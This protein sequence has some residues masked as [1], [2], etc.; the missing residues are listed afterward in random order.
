M[1]REPEYFTHPMLKE[2]SLAYRSYQM[3][4][5]SRA[6]E[7][8]SLVVLPTG[9]GK[10]VVA[11]L[12]M[13]ARLTQFQEGKVLMLS[14]T[15]PLVSQ[16]TS[17]LKRVLTL[18]DEV[19]MLTGDVPPSKRAELWRDARVIVSTPQ[20]IEND[21]VA[22][23]LGLEDVVLVVFD[24][25]HRAVGSYAYTYIAKKYHEQAEHPLVLGITA[26]PGANEER[27]KE[28]CEGLGVGAVYTKSE[29]DP[30][31]RRY[32]HRKDIEWIEVPVPKEMMQLRNELE[33]VMEDRLSEL[34][35]LGVEVSRRPTRKQL[36]DVQ[37]KLMVK[38]RFSPEPWVYRAVSL[39]AEML[40][41]SHGVELVE[42]QGMSAF[43]KYAE[44]LRRE[45][46]SSKASKAARR[47]IEDVHFKRALFL[48]E[49]VKVE[50]PKLKKVCDIVKEELSRNPDSRIIVFTNYRDSSVVVAE[51]LSAIEGVRATRF[52]GQTSRQDDRGLS[53]K[54]QIDIIE[55][56]KAG[57]FNV[58][59]ATS[60]AEEGLDIPSTDLVVFYEPVPSEIRSIQRKGRTGRARVGRVVVLIA[61]G[62][63]DVGAYWSSVRKERQMSQ[64]MRGLEHVAQ[65]EMG[66][67]DNEARPP[68]P[69]RAL[70]EF[71]GSTPSGSTPIVYV[72]SREL[73]SQVVKVLEEL[74][75][76]IRV[77]TMEVGDY[78]VSERVAIERKTTPDL[79]S[80]FIDGERDL[81]LQLSDLSRSYDRPLLV[82][83]GEDVYTARRVHPN[84]IRGLLASIAVDFS[85]PL[86]FT[87]D[88]RETAELI[89]ILA[90][91]EQSE[92]GEKPIIRG[93]KSA[94]TLPEQQE[95]VLSSI[96][97][98]GQKAARNLLKHFGSIQA[99]LNASE[100]ELQQVPLIGKKTARLIREVVGSEY[101]G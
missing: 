67:K 47:L 1:S 2:N 95:Y 7:G 65:N 22:K 98:V 30:D 76:D 96:P 94:R 46:F 18:D 35:K 61:K 77:D 87:R 36:L 27:V 29:H 66:E 101:K 82:V 90:R 45:A 74:G 78:V 49:G 17:F 41:L 39:V 79:L 72:D 14:P 50:H 40:K 44:R 84:A 62:T 97:G 42:S 71:G 81:F 24:E 51:A 48:L 53:Q 73:R 88:E 19:V 92:R 75:M 16:H 15:K 93:K 13:V 32:V 26:S 58:L 70:S 69:Q 21:L 55:R 91:R 43:R 56:F 4:L 12:A 99:V 6:L 60:V 20:V 8:S 11:V 68:R 28:V 86:L 54:E 89:A 5:A 64:Q 25:A 37:K 38:L 33:K 10:T 31:V 83:E 57:E 34:G 85:I 59:V 80:S 63:R 52:V 3:E 9:L 100:K 23:R